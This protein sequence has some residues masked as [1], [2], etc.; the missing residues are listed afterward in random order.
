MHISLRLRLRTT[1]IFLLR[2]VGQSK[3]QGQPSFKSWG[4]IFHF[5]MEK[6]LKSHSKGSMDPGKG[7]KIVSIFLRTT[8]HI[9]NI[10][11]SKKFH[12]GKDSGYSYF[13]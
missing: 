11:F 6:A 8:Q 4:N 3:S 10:Q 1:T 12:C 2:F 7:K 5:L 9:E 13:M